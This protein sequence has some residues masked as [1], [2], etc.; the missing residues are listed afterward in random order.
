MPNP[1]TPTILNTASGSDLDVIVLT[2]P[3][4]VSIQ[5]GQV[6]DQINRGR[7]AY[8]PPLQCVDLKDQITDVIIETTVQGSSLLEV[9]IEDPN[10]TL[11]ARD[12]SGNC[13]IDVDEIG[14][15]WPPIEINF[16]QDA[17]DAVWRL[18]Q[19]RPSTDLSQSNIILVFEDQVVAE[20]REY[21]GP[22]VSSPNQTRAEFI[23][24]L[25]NEV[26][27][28]ATLP[29]V[30]VNNVS[31]APT[32]P[33][34]KGDGSVRFVPLLKIGSPTAFTAAD[35]TASQVS[36]PASAKQPNAPK[37][38]KNPN[39]EVGPRPS[40]FMPHRTTSNQIAIGVNSAL[41]NPFVPL[42]S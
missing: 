33:I 29:T 20:M 17:S 18:A 28:N 3:D 30:S 8:D 13:F 38:R 14:Y 31:L 12:A 15:L 11:F 7:M 36:R 21:T 24:Q 22:V 5:L 4:V 34:G 25:V 10:W 37:A 9:H 27:T 6:A 16:P 39:K 41:N 23:R 2:D 26:R 19:C 1:T 35:L 42:G 32:R 40:P